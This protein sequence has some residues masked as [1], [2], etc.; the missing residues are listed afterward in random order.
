MFYYTGTRT[1]VNTYLQSILSGKQFDG[2]RGLLQHGGT[3]PAWHR[4]PSSVPSTAMPV[5]RLQEQIKQRPTC[6]AKSECSFSGKHQQLLLPL[7][8]SR[9]GSGRT[10]VLCT[11]PDRLVVLSRR[12]EP[13]RGLGPDHTMT[14]S[15][16]DRH[17]LTCVPGKAHPL[18]TS[19]WQGTV[20][21]RSNN[22]QIC[23]LGPSGEMW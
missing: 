23:V 1:L 17:P 20:A 12:P 6:Q 5:C 19:F 10:A 21:R 15:I 4:R 14:H 22:S 3:E 13:V 7:R 18:L 16:S 11:C 2:V 8:C 9:R